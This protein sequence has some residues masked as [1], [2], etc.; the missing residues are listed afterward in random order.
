VLGHHIQNN[1]L[2]TGFY[3]TGLFMMFMNNNCKKIEISTLRNS[4]NAAVNLRLCISLYSLMMLKKQPK[5]VGDGFHI[6]I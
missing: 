4:A 5:H 2:Y 3:D 1:I 6:K